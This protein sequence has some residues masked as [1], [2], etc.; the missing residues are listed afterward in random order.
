LDH[1]KSCDNGS[2]VDEFFAKVD[3]REFNDVIFHF[4]NKKRRFFDAPIQ[5]VIDLFP[6]PASLSDDISEESITDDEEYESLSGVLAK[7]V[8]IMANLLVKFKGTRTDR[9][10]QFLVANLGTDLWFE[11]LFRFGNLDQ[12]PAREFL[13]TMLKK[14]I[15]D[16]HDLIMFEKKDLRRCWFTI[17]NKRYFHHA[18]ESLEIWR[19]AKYETIMN[20]LSDMNLIDNSKGMVRLSR[21]G[22]IFFQNLKRDYY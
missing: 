3:L 22:T 7:F 9:R 20:F 13:K 1:L 19:P 12:M 15:I 2:T 18:D 10:Y 17:E 5:A 4:S 14:Y 11:V 8:L 6:K 21:E 16:Q